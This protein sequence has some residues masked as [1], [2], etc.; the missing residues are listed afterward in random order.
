MWRSWVPDMPGIV[1]VAVMGWLP[2][3]MAVAIGVLVKSLLDRC[4]PAISQRIQRIGK[5]D[6]HVA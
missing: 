3:G 1:A 2:A 4:W 6:D 5:K